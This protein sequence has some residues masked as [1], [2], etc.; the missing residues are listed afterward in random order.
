[1]PA[2]IRGDA[3]SVHLAGWPD[4]EVPADEAA[5]LREAYEVVLTV[6]EA[7]TKA[8]EEARIAGAVGKSQEALLSI[9]VP[10]SSLAVLEARGRVSLAEMF[11]VSAVELHAGES[12]EVSVV[13]TRAGGEKCPR[14][15]NWRELG[16]DGLCARC[17]SVVAD[18]G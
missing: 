2:T 1:M 15:W 9:T 11:I 17:S 13:V 6:R 16:S 7:V 4:V 18:L 5:R 10:A 14:C 3:V 12:E 8:I